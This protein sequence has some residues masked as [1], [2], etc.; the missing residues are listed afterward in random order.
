[1]K[2]GMLIVISSNSKEYN[3]G[4]VSN[5]SMSNNHIKRISLVLF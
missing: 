1:M 5:G 4:E 3:N 2:H